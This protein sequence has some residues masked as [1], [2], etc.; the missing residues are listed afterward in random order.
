MARRSQSVVLPAL[1]LASF[2]TATTCLRVFA[3]IGG[4]GAGDPWATRLLVDIPTIFVIVFLG[5]ALAA[6]AEAALDELPLDVGETT[7]EVRD[8]ARPLAAFAAL[9]SA[10]WVGLN[11]VAEMTHSSGLAVALTFA[12]YG[13]ALYAIPI[14]LLERP[15]PGEAIASSWRLVRWHWRE[16]VGG[17]F[18]LAI[19]G[20][21]LLLPG[22]AILQHAAALNRETSDPQNALIVL[23]VIASSLAF[24]FAIAARECF[25]VTVYRLEVEDLPGVAYGGVA[26]SRRTRAFR[27]ARG[28]AVVILIVAAF[29]AVTDGDHETLDAA[30][31]PGDNYAI[32]VS[33]EPESISSG[34]PVLYSG[35]QIG[36]VLGAQPDSTGLR[37]TFHVEPGYG[38]STTP[39]SF[40]VRPCGTEYCLVLIPSGAAPEES[41]TL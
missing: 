6:A 30:R 22:I 32:V 37:V 9:W 24:A 40:V 5:A 19:F 41:E 15:G 12:W 34:S 27:V 18:A 17:L 10:G 7:E 21:L 39:G 2:L 35:R 11:L 38:P 29:T 1:A 33:A 31:A 3:D 26:P 13:V 16:T 20:G 23:G 4:P 25:A 36:V 8:A 14:V 28:F